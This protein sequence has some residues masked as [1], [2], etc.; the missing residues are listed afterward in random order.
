MI[1]GDRNSDKQHQNDVLPFKTGAWNLLS[2]TALGLAAQF[3][4]YCKL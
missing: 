3:F 1:Q 2:L 4:N